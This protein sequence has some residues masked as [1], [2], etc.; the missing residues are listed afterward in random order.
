MSARACCGI[1][2]ADWLH[3]AGIHYIQLHASEAGKPV[4]EAAGFV[5]GRYP[6]MDL[7]TTSPAR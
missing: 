4:Y 3:E 1:T 7:I 6:G 5:I 2:S